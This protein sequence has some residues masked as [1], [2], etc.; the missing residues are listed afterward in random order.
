MPHKR[1]HQKRKREEAT[2]ELA[3]RKRKGEGGSAF[4]KKRHPLSCH[5]TE[6][7]GIGLVGINADQKI[8]DDSVLR[9]IRE[10]VGIRGITAYRSCGKGPHPKLGWR[11]NIENVD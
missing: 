6:G 7:K 8:C 3:L 9:F 11:T 2:K 4:F 10:F 1:R 5:I